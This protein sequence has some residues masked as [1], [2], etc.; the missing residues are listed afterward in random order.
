MV[1]SILPWP[2]THKVHSYAIRTDHRPFKIGVKD[3]NKSNMLIMCS[4]V[5]ESAYQVLA[6]DFA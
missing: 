5:L 4:M 6:L 1:I 3:V 2:F